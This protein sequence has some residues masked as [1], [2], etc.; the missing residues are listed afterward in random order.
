MERKWRKNINTLDSIIHRDRLHSFIL[1]YIRGC[2]RNVL[3]RDQDANCKLKA[4]EY[5]RIARICAFA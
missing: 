3:H 1:T 4:C 5:V 2:S